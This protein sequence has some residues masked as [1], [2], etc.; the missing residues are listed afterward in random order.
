MFFITVVKIKKTRK[1]DL[2]NTSYVLTHFFINCETVC[3]LQCVGFCH[4]SIVNMLKKR[5][6][7]CQFFVEESFLK[8]QQFF[9][10]F[11]QQEKK[12]KLILVL[13][14]MLDN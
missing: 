11:I 10:L 14:K 1:T 2:C 8:I 4:E 7:S 9:K 13:K 5:K 12:E 6:C 3:V